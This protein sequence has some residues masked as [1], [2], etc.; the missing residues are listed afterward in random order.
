MQWL[1]VLTGAYFSWDL[2]CCC[3]HIAAD[4]VRAMLRLLKVSRKHYL[5]QLVVA[6]TRLLD[7][8]EQSLHATATHRC[9]FEQSLQSDIMIVHIQYRCNSL[10][11]R[12]LICCTAIMLFTLWVTLMHRS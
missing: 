8:I 2:V 11:L 4:V 3:L 12:L 10:C 5:L 1:K 9:V 6:S 7:R